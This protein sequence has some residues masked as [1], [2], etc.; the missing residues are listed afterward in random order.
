MKPILTALFLALIIPCS[1][2]GHSINLVQVA[3][4]RAVIEGEWKEHEPEAWKD[5][6]KKALEKALNAYKITSQTVAKKGGKVKITI[7]IEWND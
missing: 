5:V 7:T 3:R 2:A 6:K 4:Y 1:Y